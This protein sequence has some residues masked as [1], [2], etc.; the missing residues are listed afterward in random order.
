MMY[1]EIV[2]SS[3]GGR[4]RVLRE[5]SLKNELEDSPSLQVAI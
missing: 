5:N 3:A 2:H 4:A 1:H